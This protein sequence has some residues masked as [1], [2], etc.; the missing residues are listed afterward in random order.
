MCVSFETEGGVS[1]RYRLLVVVL[2][3]FGYESKFLDVVGKSLG[4]CNFWEISHG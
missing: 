3:G 2:M 4:Y 1:F